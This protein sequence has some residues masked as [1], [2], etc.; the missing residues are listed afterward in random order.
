MSGRSG[1]KEKGQSFG[2]NIKLTHLKKI[3]PSLAVD[4][5]CPRADEVGM[6]SLIFFTSH[7][8]A[9]MLHEDHGQLCAGGVG[10]GAPIFF[11]EN[12]H[13]KNIGAGR[14]QDPRGFQRI[15]IRASKNTT[16]L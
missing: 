15:K 3:Y 4:A 1:G 14:R 12:L 5:F 9:S 2:Q 13:E 7:C 10:R 16:L 6:Q 11:R 8:M